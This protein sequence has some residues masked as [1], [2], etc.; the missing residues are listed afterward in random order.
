[1]PITTTLTVPSGT[2]TNTTPV[3]VNIVFSENVSGL[4][5]QDINVINGTAIFLE[6]EDDEYVVSISPSSQDVTTYVSVNAGAASNEFNE[7]N[8]ESNTVDFS[9]LSIAP[10][11][12]L[13]HSI[14]DI[15]VDQ[16]IKCTVLFDRDVT[17]F[18]EDDIYL[19]NVN[20]ESLTGSG[21]EYELTLSPIDV[22]DFSFGVY[23][24]A[25]T[26]IY[27]NSSAKSVEVFSFY[28][29]VST[30]ERSDIINGSSF[31]IDGTAI[32]VGDDSLYGFTAQDLQTVV[33]IQSLSDCAKNVPQRLLEKAITSLFQKV[34]DTPTGEELAKKVSQF[35]TSIGTIQ[36]IVN[37]VQPAIEDPRSL[38]T[39]ILEARGLTEDALRGKI[40]TILSDYADV[41]GI[42]DI[43]SNIAT[44]DLCKMDNYTEFGDR[45]YADA[46][47]PSYYPPP[48]V[49]GVLSPLVSTY[50]STAKDNYD[51][52]NFQ[53]R[54]FLEVGNFEDQTEER[55]KMIGVV[56][57]LALSYHDDISKTTDNS[58]DEDFRLKYY[59]NV[60][61]EKEKNMSW[62]SGIMKS[63]EQRT[64]NIGELIT[65]NVDVIRVFFNKNSIASG[66]KIS[67]GVTTYSGPDKD[68]TTFLD[69]KASQRPPELTAY[70]SR[71]YDIAAQE[72]K[73]RRRGIIPQTL[74]YSDAYNGAYGPLVSDQT[75]ASSRFPGD[76]IIQ[77]KRKDGTIYDPTGKNPSGQYKVTDTG[78]SE[79][80]FK[81]VD[82]FT[83]QPEKYLGKD[84]VDVYLI[85]LGTRKAK[86]FLQAQSKYGTGF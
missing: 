44:L 20:I 6:G 9:F 63:F 64:K 54:E 2:H 48:R 46:H 10:R 29:Y 74:N 81:K 5:L 57:T 26:D 61:K 53:L 4:T 65:R 24:D 62:T 73:L 18:S 60:E 76:S 21:S 82:I 67:T 70:W 12:S 50:D 55:A 41:D 11:V 56:N 27:G 37:V 32:E 85:S 68:F 33:D 69:I 7:F 80:T 52:M 23:A 25:G 38:V 14:P 83:S 45:Q 36:S 35:S 42:T 84:D 59:E 51:A 15:Y 66:K 16:F 75:V 49:D 77:L 13:I 39:D 22:G 43:V 1:M 79:L 8:L 58:K 3:T 71:K 72:A 31:G 30:G 78:N 28:D 40:D 47:A 19:N 34:A 86:R 17:G